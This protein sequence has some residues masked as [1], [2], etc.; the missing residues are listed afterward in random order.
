MKLAIK[1]L[2]KILSF[3]NETLRILALFAAIIKQSK[4]TQNKSCYRENF[5]YKNREREI[6]LET[7]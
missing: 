4:V 6:V 5:Y 7:E 2:G 3:E 1:E